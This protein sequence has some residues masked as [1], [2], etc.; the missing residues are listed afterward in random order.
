[1]RLDR[2]SK[3]YLSEEFS[4][5][6]NQGDFEHL[7]MK[8]DIEDEHFEDVHFYS[9]GRTSSVVRKLL[10]LIEMV[11]GK[12]EMSDLI[13]IVVEDYVPSD[14]SGINEAL[15]LSGYEV[16]SEGNIESDVVEQADVPEIKPKIEENLS[17]LEFDDVLTDYNEGIN[18][19]H[20]GNKFQSL[21]RCLEGLV[22]KILEEEGE[23]QGDSRGNMR[24]L[25]NLEVLSTDPE[26]MNVNGGTMELELIH[27]YGIYSLLSHYLEHFNEYSE[28][29]LH[30]IFAQTVSLI[31]LLTQRYS[32][33]L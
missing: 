30:F 20:Q 7:L 31:W 16:D 12:D 6:L 8:M 15:K 17:E 5:Y 33:R 18:Q 1:M 13:R 22:E 10:T 14:V 21:R 11:N 23:V 2:D 28:E 9:K 3:A 24:K 19:Y 27:S 29:D 4:G 32:N 26:P 25:L